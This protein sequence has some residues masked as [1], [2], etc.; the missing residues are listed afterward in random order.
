MRKIILATAF[1]AA[2]GLG[3]L[4]AQSPSGE[5]Q[6]QGAGDSREWAKCVLDHIKGAS[7]APLA[8]TLINNA[9]RSMT[10]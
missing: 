3:G 10:R 1:V 5:V 4:F 6:A 9:C 8:P 2:F 7:S